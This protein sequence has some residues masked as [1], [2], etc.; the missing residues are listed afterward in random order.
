MKKIKETLGVV[1]KAAQYSFAFCLRNNKKDTIAVGLLLVVHTFIGYGMIVLMGSLISTVQTYLTSTKAKPLTVQEFMDGKYYLPVLVFVGALFL[2]IIVQKYKS[3]ISGRQ[4]HILRVANNQEINKLKASLDIGRRKSKSY[5]DLEKKIDELPD[6]WY[7]RISLTRELVELV[8]SLFGFVIFGVSLLISNPVYVIILILSS[9]PMVFAEFAAVSRSWKLSLELI[10]HHKKRGV[11]QQAYYGS[12]AFLQ[13]VMFNQFPFL[14]RQ[15]QENQDHVI[16]EADRVQRLN[17]QITLGA[18]LV[19]IVGLSIVFIHSVSSTL[20]TAGDI[21]ALTVILAST[22]RLQSFVREITFQIANQWQS[23]KGM[24][25]IEEEFFSLKPLLET[26]QPVKPTFFGPPRIRFDNVCFNYPER[27]TLV[28]RNI[29]LTIEPGSKTVIIGKSGSGKSSLIG[30]LLRH[31]DPCS[32]S[33]FV[34]DVELR[35]IDPAD[36]STYASALLQ[37][38]TIGRRKIGD[39]IASSRLEKPVE[40]EEVNEV[41]DFAGF[42]S[43]VKDDPDG[44]NSQIGTDFGGREFSGGEEQRLAL[45]RV[46][47]RKTPILILDEPDSKLDPETAERLIERVFGLKGVTIIIVTQHISRATQADKIVV[48]DQGSIIESGTH[49]ELLV[50]NGKYKS[51]F[52]LDKNRLGR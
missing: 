47:Y 37:N 18:Y 1:F 10:P 6:S 14:S 4:R 25:M 39:E 19:Q 20:S 45:A 13:G 28:L 41:S 50:M 12:T 21:G 48:L 5:D 26:K 42:S 16:R 36:W 27:D 33:I 15:I 30:L 46:R 7:T 34:G 24:I 44:F 8:G 51:M 52:L 17:L 40:M 38:F 22:R 23:V 49:D 11:L 2:E 29:T 43:V 32:G 3:Y 35:R 31:Y 9:I